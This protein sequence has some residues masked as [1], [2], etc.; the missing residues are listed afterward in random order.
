LNPTPHPFM[1]TDAHK[2]QGHDVIIGHATSPF[3]SPCAISYWWLFVAEA[4]LRGGQVEDHAPPPRVRAAV[5]PSGP[6][7]ETGCKV[8][9]LR[10]TCI[11]S[12]ASYCWCQITPF[13]RL[14]IRPMSSGILAP[15][16]IQIWLPHWPP[17]TAAAR[18]ARFVVSTVI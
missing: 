10:N 3:D 1:S 2:H 9:R 16:Q 8:T 17:Q 11:Y 14:R 7:N 6:P 13:A 15:P 18:N 5:D 4:V 12:V